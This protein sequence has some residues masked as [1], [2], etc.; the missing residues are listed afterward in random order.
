MYASFAIIG[1][2]LTAVSA[3]LVQFRSADVPDTMWSYPWTSDAFVLVCVLYAVFHALVLVGVLGFARS[4]ATGTSRVARTGGALAV[5]GTGVLLVAELASILFRADPLDATGPSIVGGVFG[6]G[7]L[8]IGVGFLM[9]GVATV[10][11]GQW[12]GWRRYVPLAAG[13]WT[14]V[15]VGLAATGGLTLGVGV[16]GLCM[17]ALGLALRTPVAAT[18][19]RIAASNP[20]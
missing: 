18:R 19:A 12:Q 11:A 20:Q 2:A 15:L 14:T 16:Y 5:A 8:L 3:V 6:L 7:T 10:R 17:L 1:G 4:G 9:A 13:V